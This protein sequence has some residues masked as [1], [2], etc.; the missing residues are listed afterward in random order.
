MSKIPPPYGDVLVRP[1]FIP[2]TDE[3]L[4]ER[5]PE[6]QW[7]EPQRMTTFSG[8]TGLS[9]RLCIARFGIAG[10]NVA[11]LPKTIEEFEEHRRQYHAVTSVTD[12]AQKSHI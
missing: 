9:C 1:D 11:L 12:V 10:R 6:I 4:M 5:F 2:A 8:D 3:Q 7:R